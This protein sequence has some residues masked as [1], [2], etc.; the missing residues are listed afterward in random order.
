[1]STV[2]LTR[3]LTP[4]MVERKKGVVINISSIAGVMPTS[5]L[6]AYGATKAGMI[7]F[8]ESL[9]I[10][11]ANKGIIVQCVMPLFVATKMS[12]KKPAL[13]CPTPDDYVRSVLKKVG[14]TLKCHGYWPHELQAFVY[15]GLLPRWLVAKLA[16]K[17]TKGMREGKLRGGNEKKKS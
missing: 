4:A 7:K 12:G 2:M 17:A 16:A 15:N 6:G 11:Y 1:M 5:L 14:V 8:S 13:F 3:L 9:Q 10:E